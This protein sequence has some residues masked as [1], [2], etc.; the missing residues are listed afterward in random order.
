MNTKHIRVT[1]ILLL[2]LAQILVSVSEVHA[3]QS[4]LRTNGKIAFTSDRDGNR[5]IYVMDPDGSN[6]VRLTN[7]SVLDDH[8]TWSR[9]GRF[10]AFVSQGNDGV[11][12]IYRMDASGNNRTLI[13]PLTIYHVNWPASFSDFWSMSWS[14]DGSEIV[15]QDAWDI[16]V[17]ST[18][19]SNRRPITGASTFDH[20][21][22]WSPIS[23]EIVFAAAPNKTLTYPRISLMNSDGSNYRR[24]RNFSQFSASA[25]AWSP[26]GDKIVFVID[27]TDDI[28]HSAINTADTNG[29][30]RQV[31]DGDWDVIE[32]RNKPSW[33]PDGNS[34]LFDKWV[35]STG[36][37]ELYVKS[38]KGGEAQQLTDSIGYNFHPSWKAEQRTRPLADFDGD[39]RTDISVFRPSDSTWYIDR[40]TEGFAAHRF[41][42]S[43]DVPVPGDF[44]G[45]GRTD[46]AIFRNGAW[47]WMSSSTLTVSVEH[48]GTAG[49]QP[50]SA[51]FTGDDT[52]EIAVY[53]GGEWWIHDLTTGNSTL[54]HFGSP[55]DIPVPADYD[56]DGRVDPAVYR[57][58]EWHVNGSLR[59]YS[60]LAFGM[61]SD[62]PVFGDYD[63]DGQIDQAVYRDGVW[64]INGSASGYQVHQFGNLSDVPVPGD[65]DGDG[66]TDMAIYRSGT[67]WI[68]QSAGGLRIQQFG[69]PGDV[70][71]PSTPY[72]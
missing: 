2:S 11:Y 44:D 51:D 48:F 18:D 33:S 7:N 24:L 38:L 68:L 60:V 57:N 9:D 26:R 58:G 50:L 71:A 15:F 54:H 3:Q 31:V 12:G 55:T 19:G 17:V 47:W 72:R 25:P 39:G 59:G 22:A 56:G 40:S 13:T 35:F 61:G 46:I 8:P 36:D 20:E 27:G 23:N 65:Y 64:H 1:A 21:P 42:M 16:F 62:K 52:D 30:G 29:E 14:P 67:W 28:P 63:G 10:I 53:R 70:P 43:T 66:L 41:G 37:M 69:A 32:C 45:D 4:T 5:E 6:Q 34:I 49:D